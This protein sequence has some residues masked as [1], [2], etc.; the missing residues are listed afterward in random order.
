MWLRPVTLAFLRA[1]Q[2]RLCLGSAFGGEQSAPS[3]R[4]RSLHERARPREQPAV[5]LP[6]HGQAAALR[7]FKG[8]CLTGTWP[9]IVCPLRR[10]LVLPSVSQSSP[11]PGDICRN[12]G[13]GCQ[14]KQMQEDLPVVGEVGREENRDRVGG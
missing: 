11:W 7:G 1:E 6:G 12:A 8:S 14:A 9:G 10:L 5:S 2:M 13:V 3:G 4:M